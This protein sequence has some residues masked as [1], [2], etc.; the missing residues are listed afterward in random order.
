MSL[1]SKSV[2]TRALERPPKATLPAL[3]IGR[4]AIADRE[5]RRGPSP[6]LYCLIHRWNRGRAVGRGG[7]LGLE[8]VDEVDD[9]EASGFRP[10]RMQPRAMAMAMWLSSA[11]A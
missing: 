6:P 7:G 4:E 3:S 2:I 11:A 9:I 1:D 5:P 8:L 10:A